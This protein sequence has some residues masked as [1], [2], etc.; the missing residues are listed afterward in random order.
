MPDPMLVVAV[1][2]A[3]VVVGGGWTVVVGLRPAQPSLST[4][5]ALLGDHGSHE[6]QALG[7]RLVDENSRLER[8]G[9]WAYRVGRVPVS[10][11]TLQSLARDG[12]SVGD[13]VVNKLILAVVGLFTPG[14]L[15]V[16]LDPL[17][18][19]GVMVPVGVGIIAAVIGWVW[20]DIAMRTD[21]ARADRDAQE[22]VNT[23][24][25]LVL[26]ERLANQSAT[27]ALESA[28]SL[29][30]VPVFRQIR[31][32]LQQARLEQ[33]PPWR[34]L[35]RCA[36]ELALPAIG[37]LADVMRLE[38]QGAALADVLAA[39]VAEL[40]DAHLSGEKAAATRTSERMTVWMTIP[41]IIF[42]LAMLI[43]PMLTMA[44]G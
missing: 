11:R 3:A 25:D 6:P 18:D 21:R 5:L 13:Y 9:A 43:P 12:R 28:A 33:R 1:V 8:I 16:V 40:R 14:L 44:A 10:E 4:A 41:V 15:A 38:D 20:P 22:A 39:R 26:L 36:T 35:H 7:P 31:A 29:S 2:A 37:D 32:A 30:D 17:L 23:Y 34:D 42:A 27:G 19:G 24:F